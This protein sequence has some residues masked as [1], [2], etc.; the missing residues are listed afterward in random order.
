MGT[1]IE[2]MYHYFSYNIE[3]CIKQYHRRSNVE[4][5]FS[6]IKA[7]FGDGVRSK[8]ERAQSMSRSARCSAITFLVLSEQV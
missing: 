4:S 5:S 8:T 1:I 2:K 7:K 3:R 6:M